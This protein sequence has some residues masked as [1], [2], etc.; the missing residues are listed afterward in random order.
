MRGPEK[1]R[2]D[3]QERHTNETIV[4][5]LSRMKLLHKLTADH[6]TPWYHEMLLHLKQPNAYHWQSYVLENPKLEWEQK[7]CLHHGNVWMKE[8]GW[9]DHSN[10]NFQLFYEDIMKLLK[11]R[12]VL[13]TETEFLNQLRRN[14]LV[15]VDR[16]DDDV[17]VS[18]GTAFKK[19]EK[20][21]SKDLRDSVRVEAI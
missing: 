5:D 9:Y 10:R 20:M 18:W 12:V 11:N 17:L 3:V 21:F 19:I 15:I 14:A 2:M 1:L 6:M 16:L 7:L 8:K 4:Q 13:N